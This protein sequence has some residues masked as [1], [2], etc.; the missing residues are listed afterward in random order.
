VS[1]LE[2]QEFAA[3]RRGTE[4]LRGQAGWCRAGARPV[5][6]ERVRA[7]GGGATVRGAQPHKPRRSCC[8]KRTR[9]SASRWG[10]SGWKVS[11]LERKRV[12][13]ARRRTE[14]RWQEIATLSQGCLDRRP[15]KILCP[16]R[17]PE[18]ESEGA[19]GGAL[20]GGARLQLLT[21]C[22][23]WQGCG[24]AG[25]SG[26]KAA[27]RAR[28]GLPVGECGGRPASG[29]RGPAPQIGRAP[30]WSGGRAR[31]AAAMGQLT[32]TS[33]DRAVVD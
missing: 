13:A 8:S 27:G 18:R 21:Q 9:Q 6:A 28:H 30:R 31:L 16:G 20:G 5:D 23:A 10:W 24:P 22:E 17:G 15:R 11:G 19:A 25:S 29:L 1:G 14:I 7:D 33:W 2:R 32:S 12:A 26:S 4:S 3:A